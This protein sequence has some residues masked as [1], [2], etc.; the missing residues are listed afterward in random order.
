MVSGSFGAIDSLRPVV[1]VHSHVVPSVLVDRARRGEALLSMDLGFSE[2]GI[3]NWKLAGDVGSMEWDA[4]FT[5][6]DER[7]LAMDRD[8]IDVQ[9]LSINPAMYGYAGEPSLAAQLA[10]AVNDGIAEIVAAAPERFQGLAHLPMQDGEAA[11]RGTAP[12]G[13]RTGNGRSRHRDQ[14]RRARP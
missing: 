12:G 2:V 8:G 10:A 1:D 4:S 13:D 5:D 7:V 14:Y 11:T 9:L 3:L 6:A